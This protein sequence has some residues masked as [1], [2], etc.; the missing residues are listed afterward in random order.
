MNIFYLSHNVDECARYH[1]DKHVIK[2]IVEYAQ[3]LSTTHRVLDGKLYV[4]VS[5]GRQY[6]RWML[7]DEKENVLYKSTHFNNPSV[8]WCRESQ[9]NY[10]WLYNLFLRLIAEYYYRYKKVHACTKLIPYLGLA[11]QNINWKLFTEPTPVMGAEYI[12]ENNS[13]ESYRNFYKYGKQHLHS[14]KNRPTPTW[15]L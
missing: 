9:Q 13:L 1:V 2:Q 5:S 6:K 11:P 10:Y 14:W 8:K 4:D 3:I 12:I 15:I 7:F